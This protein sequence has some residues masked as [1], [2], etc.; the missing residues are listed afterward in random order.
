VIL[1]YLVMV[2]NVL[3]QLYLSEDDALSTQARC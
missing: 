1:F 2:M 3:R